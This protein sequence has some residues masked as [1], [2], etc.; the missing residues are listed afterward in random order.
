[1][2]K[3]YTL[4]TSVRSQEEF[5]GILNKFGIQRLIDVRRFPTS[6]LS[7]FKKNNLEIMLARE[8]IEYVYL[9]ALLGGYREE[10]Y[11]AYMSSELFRQGIKKLR[12]YIED[13]VSCIVCAEKL[14][15][16]CHRRFIA[17]CLKENY[18][19]VHIIEEDFIQEE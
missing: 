1:M 9:G 6:K 17:Q 3:V 11:P 19:V 14:Y 4:G 10:G 8:N 16:K 7:H 2:H 13:K 18:A 12:S 15:Q 5:R